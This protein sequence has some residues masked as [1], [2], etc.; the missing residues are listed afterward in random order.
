MAPEGLI[1]VPESLI[2]RERNS[3]LDLAKLEATTQL[4]VLDKYG[5]S[6]VNNST[7]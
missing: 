7:R 4:T 2:K 3:A 5:D 1:N 6:D